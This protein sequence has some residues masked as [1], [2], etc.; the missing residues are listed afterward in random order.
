MQKE[1][2]VECHANVL[3]TEETEEELDSLDLRYLILKNTPQLY[4][5]ILFLITKLIY[6]LFL[7]VRVVQDYQ[8]VKDI[9]EMKVDL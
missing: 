5:E 8:E 7:S 1:R 4:L 9:L 2:S 6:V 3:A